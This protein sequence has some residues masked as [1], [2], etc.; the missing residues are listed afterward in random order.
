MY[1][2]TTK[3]DENS[4]TYQECFDYLEQNLSNH[5]LLTE[6]ERQE[7]VRAV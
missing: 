7:C 2:T 6:Y 5:F 3:N 4:T 1:L